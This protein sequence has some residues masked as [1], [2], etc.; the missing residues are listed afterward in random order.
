MLFI[1]GFIVVYLLIVFVGIRIFV[2]YYGFRQSPVPQKIPDFVETEIKELKK[3]A[4]SKEEYLRKVYI[5]LTKRYYGGRFT[6]LIRGY[7]A[8]KDIFAVHDGFL[9]CNIFNQIF[10]IYLV[11]SNYFSDEEIQVRVVFLN[12]FIHQYIKVKVNNIWIDVDPTYNKMG[13]ILGE[14]AEFF[15]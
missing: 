9:P 3:E 5:T 8:F 12:C 2:P 7:D 6:T 15:R 10:R 4:N 14:H 13:V 1:L 11:K